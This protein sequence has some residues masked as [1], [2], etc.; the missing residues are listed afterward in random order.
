M[1][2]TFRHKKLINNSVFFSLSFSRLQITNLAFGIGLSK[3]T[4]NSLKID[5]CALEDVIN[6]K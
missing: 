1:S 6:T 3:F 5:F 4:S 2:E